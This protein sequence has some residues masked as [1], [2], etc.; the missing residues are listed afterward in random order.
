MTSGTNEKVW[1]YGKKVDG[2]KMPAL[3]YKILSSPE[4]NAVQLPM[5]KGSTLF[6][7][8]LRSPANYSQVLQAVQSDTW[9]K[10][11]ASVTFPKFKLASDD[12]LVQ[13]LKPTTPYT[14]TLKNLSTSQGR[15]QSVQASCTF[16]LDEKGVEAAAATTV[17][18]SRGG[19]GQRP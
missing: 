12:N 11:N 16:E 8:Q 19:G 13:L 15:V 2:V 3:P 4:I 1:F 17:S 9:I 5:Q 6:F 18:F 14:P 7:I 10:Y